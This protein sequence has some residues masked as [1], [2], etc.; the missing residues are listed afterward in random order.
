M[1]KIIIASILAFSAVPAFAQNTTEITQSHQC[2]LLRIGSITAS[3]GTIDE[4]THQ[5]AAKAQ[6]ARANYFR[7]NHLNTNQLGY[8][9]A[10]LYNN[11]DAKA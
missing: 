7:I 6:N 2:E 10:T 9:T 8:A 11:A 3:T 4:L 5:L 1:K